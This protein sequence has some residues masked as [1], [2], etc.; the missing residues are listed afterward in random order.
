VKWNVRGVVFAVALGSRAAESRS[1]TVTDRPLNNNWSI[2]IFGDKMDRLVKMIDIF[3]VNLQT[4]N[5]SA[6]LDYKGE[7]TYQKDPRAEQ[8]Y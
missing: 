6:V 7:S 1:A 4:F 2:L 8:N 5:K 3:Y